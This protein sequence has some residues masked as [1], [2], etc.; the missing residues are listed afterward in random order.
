VVVHPLGGALGDGTV[1]RARL[2]LA[3]VT[4]DFPGRGAARDDQGMAGVEGDPD[5]VGGAW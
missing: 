3:Q 2:A 1:E 4:H 5:L